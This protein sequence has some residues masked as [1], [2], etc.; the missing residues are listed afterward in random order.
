[1]NPHTQ[2]YVVDGS[3]PLCR[4]CSVDPVNANV[5]T[6]FGQ[7]LDDTTTQVELTVLGLDVLDKR[8]VR[9]AICPPIVRRK[10]VSQMS[11]VGNGDGWASLIGTLVWPLVERPVVDVDIEGNPG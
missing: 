1:M 8:L 11:A 10:L 5:S 2:L 3:D 6:L 9:I 4:C 7:F